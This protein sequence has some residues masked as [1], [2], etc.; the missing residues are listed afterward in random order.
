[1]STTHTPSPRVEKT[2]PEP[3]STSARAVAAA[4]T[5]ESFQLPVAAGRV[6]AVL[7]V[8]YGFTFL[9]AFFDKLFGLH[10]STAT[11]KSWLNGGSPTKGFL[12]SSEG[13]F[14]GFYHAIAGRGI[15]N[16]GFMLALLAI[17]L[18]LTLGIGMRLAAIGG[19]VMYLM[20]WSVVLPT[21]TNPFIDDHIVGALV[22]VLL[23]LIGAGHIWGLGAAWNKVDI[24][25]R[26]P[27]LR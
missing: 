23:A 27:I 24:V 20:M 19:A 11:A 9:W 6:A 22:V 2:T 18:A 10:F 4:S 13:P 3:V 12:S 26:Y 14:A 25:K 17:G 21:V 5:T 7:R 1:M 15:T 8:V 16:W